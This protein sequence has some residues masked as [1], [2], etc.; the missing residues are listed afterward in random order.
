MKILNPLPAN[1]NIDND[2]WIFSF[3]G[4]YWER[5]FSSILAADATFYRV[6]SEKF[7]LLEKRF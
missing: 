2:V 4:T 5:A 1:E 7:L 3:R 6:Q